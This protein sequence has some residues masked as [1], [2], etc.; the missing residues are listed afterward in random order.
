MFFRL[1]YIA[2]RTMLEFKVND[3]RFQIDEPVPAKVTLR[4]PEGEISQSPTPPDAVCRVEIEKEPEPEV[5]AMFEGL[6]RGE[7]PKDYD[8]SWL[9]YPRVA[10]ERGVIA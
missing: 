3:L 7:L 2:H 4:L 1:D 10:D 5:M 9:P 6:S 8:L